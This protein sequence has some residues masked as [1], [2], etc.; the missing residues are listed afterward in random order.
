MNILRSARKGMG[1]R[2]SIVFPGS[3]FSARLC[4]LALAGGIIS[5]LALACRAMAY[6]YHVIPVDQYD[7]GYGKHSLTAALAQAA[8]GDTIIIDPGAS[9]D[10]GTVTVSLA[11]IVIKGSG[12][13]GAAGLPSYNL[14]ISANNVTLSNM[15]LGTVTVAA[16]ANN[17]TVTKSRLFSFVETGATSGAGHNTISW[18]I[19][20]GS[21]NLGGNSGASQ[22]TFDVVD[23]NTFF[24]AQPV[25]LKLTNSSST[26]VTS[27][28]MFSDNVNGIGIQV[29]SNSD[30]VTIDSNR[31]IM[32]GTG[33]TYGIILENTGGAAGNILGASVLRNVVD[34]SDGYSHLY[35][36][37]IYIN[38]F[39]T[40]SAMVAKVEG[41]QLIENLVGI[42]VFGVSGSTGAGNVDLGGGS[43][44]FGTSLGGNRFR[45]F[46]G[47]SG[48][49]AI[50]LHGTDSGIGVSAQQNI[51][52]NTVTPGDVV[53]DQTHNSGTGVIDTSNALDA[54]HAFVQS[55]F[56]DQY[57]RAADPAGEIQTYVDKLPAKKSAGVAK[58][59]F[60]S[61][62]SLQR[63]VDQTF[64]RLL[65]RVATQSE[66]SKYST[67]LK[68]GRNIS[69]V[70]ADLVAS[71]EY[72]S[73]LSTPIVEAVYQEF[74]NRTASDAE[75]IAGY[76]L[77]KSMGVKGFAARIAGGLER[78]Q[79]VAF[80]LFY[81]LLH[82]G[83]DMEEF[84]KFYKSSRN[85]LR[86][87][88]KLLM[89]DE[90]YQK[91]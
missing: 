49:F 21:V 17:T 88:L 79:D 80:N 22:G 56:E 11:N 30:S 37:G 25:L 29:F 54:D 24:S 23:S 47:A 43:T 76:K 4:R 48:H 73:S 26:A 86:L 65:F 35:G 72:Q 31:I 67:Q 83:P 52:D 20:T 59:I 87:R 69:L 9:P 89:T 85:L 57:G 36:T 50:Y 75:V 39:G 45:G 33:T 84:F 40:G 66:L 34:T 55:L 58:A 82:R 27:N 61:S 81:E 91:G 63:I 12:N 60:Y 13:A 3:R 15:N 44:S 53:R 90:Y 1:L 78:R 18:N 51:F 64:R 74:L 7:G 14:N 19:I 46:D 6:E 71:S 2:S 41:N 62:E 8:A 68:L 28:Q 42:N 10:A 70:E 5:A 16:T 77:L 38:I 32:S